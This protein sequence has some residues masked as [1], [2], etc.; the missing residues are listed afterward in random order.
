MARTNYARGYD[1]E[2][3]ALELLRAEWP[4]V[5]RAS[6][7]KGPADLVALGPRGVLLV[8]VKRDGADSVAPPYRRERLALGA[9]AL[10]ENATA[11]LWAYHP[12]RGF[13]RLPALAEPT[14]RVARLAAAAFGPVEAAEGQPV[15]LAWTV[16]VAD[17]P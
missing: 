7:S 12:K 2:R 9:L 14:V 10:P 16:T 15:G 13:R 5:V 3:R 6:A 17:A 11:E 1:V 4:L 8:Q